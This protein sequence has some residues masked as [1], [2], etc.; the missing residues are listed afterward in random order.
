MLISEI[1]FY[2][3]L[4]F[5]ILKAFWMARFSTRTFIIF[6]NKTLYF[7]GRRPT[8]PFQGQHVMSFNEKTLFF[9]NVGMKNS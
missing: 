8:F 1:C 3:E 6:T 7:K 4:F 5:F 2:G 9:L